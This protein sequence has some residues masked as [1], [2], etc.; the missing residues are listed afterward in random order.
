[1]MAFNLQKYL[2]TTNILSLFVYLF[3]CIFFCI[4]IYV[5]YCFCLYFSS[6]S[7]GFL[8]ISSYLNFLVVSISIY[9]YFFYCL[10]LF[11]HC[12]QRSRNQSSCFNLFL[13]LYCWFYCFGKLIWLFLLLALSLTIFLHFFLKIGCLYAFTSILVLLVESISKYFCCLTMYSV[14]LFLFCFVE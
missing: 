5:Y 11:F 3:F 8:C 9:A 4:F 1:M 13:W 2:S 6:Y 7:F 14:R 12:L 10:Y